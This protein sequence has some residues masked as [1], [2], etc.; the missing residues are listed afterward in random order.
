M[1]RFPASLVCTL[2]T[3]M[4]AEINS[5]ILHTYTDG[6]WHYHLCVCMYFNEQ[7]EQKSREK[8]RVCKWMNSKLWFLSSLSGEKRDT[9]HINAV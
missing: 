3:P 5:S 6:R 2:K 1:F 7:V 4:E 9:H 8:K